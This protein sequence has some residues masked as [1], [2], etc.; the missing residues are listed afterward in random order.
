MKAYYG[1]DGTKRFQNSTGELKVHQEALKK[2][3]QKALS[4]FTLRNRIPFERN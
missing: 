3:S 1:I 2:P 4:D